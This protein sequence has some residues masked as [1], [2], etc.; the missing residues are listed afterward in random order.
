M[1]LVIRWILFSWLLNLS[2]NWRSSSEFNDR[3]KDFRK[4][5]GSP[6]PWAAAHGPSAA[7]ENFFG[8]TRLNFANLT[9]S[10]TGNCPWEKNPSPTTLSWIIE[11]LREY[12]F[13]ICIWNC[14][15]FW[16]RICS[17]WSEFSAYYLGISPT[18]PPFGASRGPN[19]E[20]IGGYDKDW[21]QTDCYR[22]YRY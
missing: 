13:N 20:N 16:S 18:S 17:P 1:W 21:F 15:M 8:L 11:H 19:K 14:L 9:M 6:A 4:R 3:S 7:C 5:R 22:F 10:S 2:F 12:D